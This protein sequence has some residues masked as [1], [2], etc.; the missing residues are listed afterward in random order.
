[1]HANGQSPYFRAR[2]NSSTPRR[3]SHNSKHERD[4]QQVVGDIVCD[5]LTAEIRRKE[6]HKVQEI[7][8]EGTE[9]VQIIQEVSTSVACPQ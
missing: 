5:E 7:T 9:F 4:A 2:R 8:T 1:M 6:S 3:T